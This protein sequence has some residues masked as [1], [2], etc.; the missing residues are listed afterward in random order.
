MGVDSVG[1]GTVAVKHDSLGTPWIR[2]MHMVLGHSVTYLRCL[3]HKYLRGS[4]T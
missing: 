2:H 3:S 1:K 4:A